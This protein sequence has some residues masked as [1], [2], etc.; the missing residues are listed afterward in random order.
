MVMLK[1][2]E[3]RA[4]GL[5][6]V[7]SSI[8]GRNRGRN[9]GR[10]DAETSAMLNL[11]RSNPSITQQEVAEQAGLTRGQVERCFA[12]LKNSGMIIRVGSTKSGH[13]AVLEQDDNQ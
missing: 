1:T 7:S 13:W 11:I 10:N 8:D 5:D 6:E 9:R 12:K 2:T 4:K 3:Q